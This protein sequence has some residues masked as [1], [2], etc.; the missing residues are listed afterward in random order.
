MSGKGFSHTVGHCNRLLR[1]V[2]RTPNLSEFK[3]RLDNAF[4]H[5][6]LGYPMQGQEL[7]F[8]ILIGPF[9][10]SIFHDSVCMYTGEN[11]L[12]PL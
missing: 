3:K 7:N 10:F 12:Y 2:V 11:S 5:M 8:M 6:E 9:Q 1:E 4:R